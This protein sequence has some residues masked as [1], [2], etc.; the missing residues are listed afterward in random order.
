[1]IKKEPQVIDLRLFDHGRTG[2]NPRMKL[3]HSSSSD[4]ELELRA[5]IVEFGRI[6]Y[7]RG[8]MVSNDGNISVRMHD[9]SILITRSGI[10]KRRMQDHDIIKIDLSG[11]P[12]V[13]EN[14]G[15]PSSELPMHLE[16]YHQRVDVRAV[17]HAHPVFATS[18]TVAGIDFPDDLLPEVILTLGRV[19]TTE[20][21]TPS[22]DEDALA[23]Q[24]L[25]KSHSAI[26][27]RQHGTLTVGKDLE[28]ALIHL[29]RIEHVA[30]IFWRA[31][32]LGTIQRI[33]PEAQ[34]RLSEQ[35]EKLFHS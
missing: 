13:T 2:Y 22:S 12:I 21:A 19:P 23:V 27:L 8:L 15:K 5:S 28:E 25:I 31:N 9:N 26:L 32:A 34:K 3:M 18:L 7:S 1:M 4:T 29:E 20:Y 10:S 30:E 16:V 11:N 14:A 6:C 33:S 24:E 35:R 17:I